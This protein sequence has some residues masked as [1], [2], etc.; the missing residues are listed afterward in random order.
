MD[1]EVR[2]LYFVGRALFKADRPMFALHLVKGMH[3]DHFQQREWEIF[4]GTLVASVTDVAP[5]GFPSWAP[6]ERQG[7]FRLLSE[8]LPHLVS[9]LELENGSKWQRFATSPEAEKDIP[10]EHCYNPRNNVLYPL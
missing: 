6:T 1:I 9:S 3:L 5:K 10:G 2:A 4:T 7:A 8:Q